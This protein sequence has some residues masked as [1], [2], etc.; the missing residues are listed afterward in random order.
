VL[1]G[2]TGYRSVWMAKRSWFRILQ[3]NSQDCTAWAG[4]GDQQTSVTDTLSAYANAVR[5]CPEQ[6][7]YHESL[8]FALEQ[9]SDSRDLQRA[10]FEH[11]KVLQEAPSRAINALAIG[12]IYFRLGNLDEALSWF[13][14]ARTVEP[15]YWE[16]YLWIARCRYEKKEPRRAVWFLNYLSLQH[17]KFQTYKSERLSGTVYRPSGYE[18]MI[19]AYDPK[20][21]ARELQRYL[22][23]ERKGIIHKKNTVG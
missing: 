22:T 20:V 17:V 8:A 23:T 13:E 16:A 6:P 21:V 11:H 4:W 9:F 3:I 2:Y 1:L 18:R 7:Y 12:R 15:H 19:I 5:S 10:L 14:K